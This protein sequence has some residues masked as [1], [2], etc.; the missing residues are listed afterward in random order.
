MSEYIHGTD[1]EEQQRLTLLNTILLNEGTL[2]ELRLREGQRILDVGS[3]LGQ[4][5]RAM[6][7]AAKT[8][9]IGIE[10]SEEQIAEAAR[11]A[12]TEGEEHLVE[13]R[14][15]DA[16]D[17]PLM[18]EEWDSFDV[19][20]TRFL[21]EHVPDPLA[22][23]RQ[24]TRAVKPGGRIILQDDDHDILRLHPEPAG[25]S[26]LWSA[27]QRTY[28]RLKNDPIVGRRLVRL[29]QQAGA[30]PL[31]N[32]WIFFGSCSGDP[33]WSVFV[34]NLIVVVNGAASHIIEIGTMDQRQ[35][36]EAV[37][38]VQVWRRRPDSAIWYAVALAEGTKP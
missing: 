4:L 1:P 35:L 10:R 31:R 22:V 27:Y 9:V 26:T 25:F 23:V 37:D 34:D 20:H 13:F 12:K 7:R 3:G 18:D 2:R 6:A 32:T 30:K 16:I 36:D 38:A 29:L 28:D 8:R 11:Q 17:L 33:N 19:A 21:L 14:Q 24:M 5:S 15:G